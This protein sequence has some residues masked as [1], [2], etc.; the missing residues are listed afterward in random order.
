M[1]SITQEIENKGNTNIEVFRYRLI[2]S[3]NTPDTINFF[4][5]HEGLISLINDE[6]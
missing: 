6:L 4:I 2:K 1:F 3:I 5:L